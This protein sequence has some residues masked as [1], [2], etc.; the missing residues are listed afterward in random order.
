MNIVLVGFKS[1]GKTTIGRKLSKVLCR[2]F[3]DIDD[4]IKALY[5]KKY[6]E[7]KTIFEILKVLKDEG[8]DV[9]QT[10][11]FCLL[12]DIEN[13]IIST[14]GRSVID[15]KKFK[16]LKKEKIIIYLKVENKNILKKRI[17]SLKEKS[18]FI[19]DSFF[20]KTYFHRQKYY[21]KIAD[22]TIVIDNKTQDDILLEILDMITIK[23]NFSQLKEKE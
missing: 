13:S 14:S 16:N 9:L 2:N 17:K 8:F 19:N 11:A 7:Q 20:E 10:Q 4:I 6:K 22:E 5:F 3:Y 21:N 18:I 1:C 23:S 15:A 12:K